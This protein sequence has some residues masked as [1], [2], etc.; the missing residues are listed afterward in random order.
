[1]SSSLRSVCGGHCGGAVYLMKVGV[2][3]VGCAHD[4]GGLNFVC[5]AS[6]VDMC[7]GSRT[8]VCFGSVLGS[9][10]SILISL[11]QCDGQVCLAITDTVSFRS[12]WVCEVITACIIYQGSTLR[13]RSIEI[14]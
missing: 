5:A 4:S 1:M 3:T 11:V 6:T 9:L 13:L 2:S 7:V 10:G 12:S 14:F 8:H